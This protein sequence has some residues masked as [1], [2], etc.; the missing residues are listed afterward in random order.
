LTRSGYLVFNATLPGGIRKR[1]QLSRFVL[2]AFSVPTTPKAQCSHKDGN[3]LNNNIKNLCW[4]TPLQNTRRKHEHG[5][6]CIG[7]RHGRAKL[8]EKQVK[9]IR[10][11]YKEG[12]RFY[13]IAREYPVDPNTI[14]KIV[15][16][17]I[18]THI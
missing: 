17:Q 10:K 2:E 5:T 14:T 18:W 4:E 16:K 11:K 7:E 8:T 3:K 6:M 13:E 9:E 1:Q 12:M 15:K